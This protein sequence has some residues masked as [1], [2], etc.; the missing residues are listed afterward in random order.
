VCDKME[1]VSQYELG[2]GTLGLGLGKVIGPVDSHRSTPPRLV[3]PS[4]LRRQF[5]SVE[6]S[7][8]RIPSRRDRDDRYESDNASSP[9]P[10][11]SS[12]RSPPTPAS[13]TKNTSKPILAFSVAAIMAK[14]GPSN[15]RRTAH[16]HQ[17]SLNRDTC[18]FQPANIR[19]DSP[20][21]DDY[22]ASRNCTRSPAGSSP[23]L[24]ATATSTTTTTTQTKRHSAGFTVDGFLNH[25]TNRTLLSGPN[26]GRDDAPSPSDRYPEDRSR[27]DS[28]D[29]H[30]ASE[31]DGSCS[32]GD[33]DENDSNPSAATSPELNGDGGP[34][35]GGDGVRTHRFL[36][37]AA[38]AEAASKWSAAGLGYPWIGSSQYGPSELHDT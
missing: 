17:V 30:D 2:L 13:T 5:D 6:F 29:I 27:L 7:M 26:P 25:Q 10:P 18:G 11:P 12:S 35:S 31:M 15:T 37:A 33:N 21:S 34:H 9:S 14:D 1:V 4:E 3:S 16:S 28:S 23:D 24:T 22:L 36:S 32:D 8:H 20:L 38:A 19:R